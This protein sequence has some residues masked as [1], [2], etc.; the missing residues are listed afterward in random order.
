MIGYWNRS[1]VYPNTYPTLS[2][3][4]ATS[5]AFESEQAFLQESASGKEHVN[6]TKEIFIYLFATVVVLWVIGVV[7]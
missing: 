4:E 6:G 1:D 2:T 3:S 5:P 7:K